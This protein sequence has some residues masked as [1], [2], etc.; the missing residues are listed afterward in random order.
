MATYL[1]TL[2]QAIQVGARLESSGTTGIFT[3]AMCAFYP[4]WTNSF[5]CSFNLWTGSSANANVT[6]RS[7]DPNFHLLNQNF[8]VAGFVEVY[9]YS[10]GYIAYPTIAQENIFKLADMINKNGDRVSSFPPDLT[11]ALTNASFDQY[12]VTSALIDSPAASAWPIGGPTYVI[13]RTGANSSLSCENQRELL[14]FWKWTLTN[15]VA[16]LRLTFDGYSSL[17]EETHEKVLA[18]LEQITCPATGTS[19]LGDVALSQHGGA[20][21]ITLLV[22]T[23]VIAAAMVIGVVIYLVR[24]WRRIP[25]PAMFFFGALLFGAVLNYISLGW[26]YLIPKEDYVCQLRKWFVALGFSCMFAAIF[27]RAFQI[28]NILLLSR[29]SKILASKK[30]QLKSLLV[31]IGTYAVIVGIQIVLLIIWTSIDPWQP[32]HSNVDDLRGTYT[33]ICSSKHNWIWFGLEIGFFASLLLFGLYVVYRSW[34]MKHLIIESKYLAVTVY[35]SLVIMI[36]VIILF[37][38]LAASDSLV[39]YVAVAAVA[40]LTSFSIA[41]FIGPK[42]LRLSDNNSL[43]TGTTGGST[44]EMTRSKRTNQSKDSKEVSK[45]KDSY[46]MDSYNPTSNDSVREER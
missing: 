12:L 40:F 24:D 5:P 23:E 45:S 35:N 44:Y 2:T 16:Q 11:V 33:Y 22:I 30:R 8:G 36:I 43:A 13:V 37:A 38:T 31:L 27:V 28:Q 20:G 21:F 39:F 25:A 32:I 46:Q 1:A 3:S 42:L 17:G 41:A 15:N 4:Q 14:L 34:D 18:E 26:F 29:S 19:I 9:E 7:S 10:L 6:A